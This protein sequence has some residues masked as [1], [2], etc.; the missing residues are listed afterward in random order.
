MSPAVLIF[1]CTVYHHDFCYGSCLAHSFSHGLVASISCCFA[2]SYLK[3]ASALETL[4]TL[5]ASS[6]LAWAVAESTA[7]PAQWCGSS[8][9]NKLIRSKLF[10]ITQSSPK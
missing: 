5:F 9:H 6:K 2:W 1:R 3:I 7:M 8:A 4:R 10:K